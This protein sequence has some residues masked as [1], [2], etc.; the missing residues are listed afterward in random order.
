MNAIKALE[1][2]CDENR[3][4]RPCYFIKQDD[5]GFYTECTATNGDVSKKC[6]DSCLK[7]D[8]I[9]NKVAFELL[10]HLLK[11][12]NGTLIS[13]EKLLEKKEAIYFIN[14]SKCISVVKEKLKQG[15]HYKGEFHIFYYK[16]DDTPELSQDCNINGNT[17]N[18]Y[19]IEPF[20]QDDN[21]IELSIMW[22]CARNGDRLADFKKIVLVSNNLDINRVASVIEEFK[23]IRPEIYS[24]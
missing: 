23:E 6:F 7:K 2:Y 16:G 21:K 17:T 5:A 14:Y 8:A 4:H 15:G 19:P 13:N 24:L 3:Y 18:L 11:R 1:I 10:Q 9:K 20:H 22:W 12:D